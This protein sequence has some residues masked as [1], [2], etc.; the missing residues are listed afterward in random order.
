MRLIWIDRS[1]IKCFDR[2]C[3]GFLQPN[4]LITPTVRNHAKVPQGLVITFTRDWI[5]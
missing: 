3:Q 1:K 2:F 4:D 5:N